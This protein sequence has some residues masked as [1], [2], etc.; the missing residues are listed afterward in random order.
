MRSTRFVPGFAALLCGCL[1]CAAPACAAPRGRLYLR[2][3]PPAPL[4][5]VRTVAPGPNVV[6]VGG[7]QRWS[8]ARYDWV[9]GRWVVPPRPRAAWVSGRWV[10]SRRGWYWVDGRWR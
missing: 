9:P 4:V 10:Q 6:W 5:Q 3:A 8:G 7:H 2:V 1:L